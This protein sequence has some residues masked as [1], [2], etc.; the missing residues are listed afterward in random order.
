MAAALKPHRWA[1]IDALRGWAIL[2]VLLVHSSQ[3]QFAIRALFEFKPSIPSDI[4]LPVWFSVICYAGENGVV[5]FFVISAVS[6]TLSAKSRAGFNLRA[7][8]V[9]RFFRIAPMY[10]FGVAIYLALFGWGP[11]LWAP[12][13]IT[14]PDVIANL[15][16]THGFRD[17]AINSVVPGGWSVA[18]EATFYVLFPFLL[19]VIDRTPRA[20][21]ALLGLS[22][23]FSM[24][25]LPNSFGVFRL[26]PVSQYYFV[27][28]VPAFVIGVATGVILS[29]NE[30]KRRLSHA[31]LLPRPLSRYQLNAEV[32]LYLLI[33]IAPLFSS[34]IT[35][36]SAHDIGR[37]IGIIL[38]AILG[39]L[40]C[41]RLHGERRS[42]SLIVNPF[43]RRIGI[44]SFSMY[45]IQFALLS[46]VY[47]LSRLLIHSHGFEFFIFYFTTLT[48]ATFGIANIT[49]ELIER[50]FI[51]FSRRLT[52][53]DEN[54]G[55]SVAASDG[56]KIIP[57]RVEN[58]R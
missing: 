10:Y 19:Y 2:L 51:I 38:T 22:V 20:Y 8:A 11:R 7:F 3:G 5:L 14:I 47:D 16:F 4:T 23:F 56:G 31:F 35:T 52:S 37:P 25:Y 13:G 41:I 54:S 15:S 6:L 9:R 33:V 32:L 1:Y 36:V 57:V 27:N 28:Y 42:V 34:M 49:Y 53:N 29:D 50:P 21:W 24:T 39:A 58:D 18:N 44:V 45:I 46:P 40:L 55:V 26:G 17:S 48:S 12:S 30:A 43:M